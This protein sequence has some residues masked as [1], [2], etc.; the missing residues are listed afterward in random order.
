MERTRKSVLTVLWR[1][2]VSLPKNYKNSAHEIRDLRKLVFCGLM[3]ALAIILSATTT[4]KIGPYLR[5]GFSGY[6][7]RIIECLFGPVVGMIFGGVLDV[8]KFFLSDGDGM[9]FFGYTFNA[10]LAGLIVGTILYRK[11]LKIWRIVLAEFLLKMLVNV[12][13]GTLWS[14]MLYGYGFMAIL[15]ARLIKNL[16]QWPVDSAILFIVLQTVLKTVK[17]VWNDKP[18]G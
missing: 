9:F 10:M 7:N 5:I 17:R 14:S 12:C 1:D 3:A 6:P 8:L 2:I 4:I 15:P 16:V 11:P 13:F 18:L